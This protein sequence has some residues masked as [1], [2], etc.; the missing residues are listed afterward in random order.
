MRHVDS[1]FVYAAGY[2]TRLRPYTLTRPKPLLDLYGRPLLAYVLAGLARAGVTRATVNAAHLAD[3]FGDVPDL[4]RALGIEVALSVQ[5]RPLMH[6]G[7]LAFAVPFLASMGRD[8]VFLAVN[9]DTVVE[10][11][12]GALHARASELDDRAP[13]LMLG[14]P[15]PGGPLRAG[16]DGLLQGI[17]D[18]DYP[19]DGGPEERWED[20]GMR[21]MHASIASLLPPP[22]GEMSLHGAGGLLGR[23]Y[24]AGRVARVAP[25]P[26]VER[27]EIG[28]VQAFESREGN[29]AMRALAERLIPPAG[30]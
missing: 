10:Y 17:G 3:A 5:D 2:G 30:R 7:D 13:V 12:A 15:A 8:E 22:G 23:A 4:G 25:A 18:V 20:F 16:A 27:A 1:A 26:V 29:T 24:A 19:V 11:D 21:L 28:T 6:G 14:A 9:G